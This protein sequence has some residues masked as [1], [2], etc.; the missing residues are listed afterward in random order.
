MYVYDHAYIRIYM[1][2]YASCACKRIRFERIALSLMHADLHEYAICIYTCDA[3]FVADVRAMHAYLFLQHRS[4]DSISAAWRQ[5][6]TARPCINEFTCTSYTRSASVYV[7][8]FC[9]HQIEIC[10]VINIIDIIYE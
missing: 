3:A 1:Y 5:A 4:I 2:I 8:I 9:M 6:T 10:V 7:I